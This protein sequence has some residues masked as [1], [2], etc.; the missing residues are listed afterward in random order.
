MASVLRPADNCEEKDRGCLAVVG[1]WQSHA[2][3]ERPII[4][5]VLAL[6]E[7]HV[8]ND[9]GYYLGGGR[10]NRLGLVG[11]SDSPTTGGLLSQSPC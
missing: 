5:S 7:T 2:E 6:Y 4:E 8:A 3:H 11:V 9:L 1:F 10:V